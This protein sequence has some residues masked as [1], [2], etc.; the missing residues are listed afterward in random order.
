MAMI[1]FDTVQ[2][3][4]PLY[5]IGDALR[6]LCGGEEDDPENNFNGQ[7]YETFIVNYLKASR[8]YLNKREKNL[9]PQAMGLV[10][11]GLA[12]RFL[13]DYIDDSYFGWD[14]KKYKSRREHNLAR[15]LGQIALYKSFLTKLKSAGVK[16]S[17]GAPI[18]FN[19][20]FS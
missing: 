9:I 15:A 14:S 5:D 11:L 6:S 4:S 3:L 18:S 12:A 13:N 16:P 1:D 7:R 19:L 17:V 8:G 10:I 20:S 2:R